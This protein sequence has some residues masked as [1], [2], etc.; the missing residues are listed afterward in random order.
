MHPIFLEFGPLTIRYY[1]LMAAVGF[2]L[3]YILLSINRKFA[4]LNADDSS[5]LI[6][7]TLITGILGSRIFYVIQFFD[8]FRGHLI[9]IVRI[10]KGG[11]VFYGGFFLALIATI[12]FCKIKKLDTIRIFDV[13]TPSLAIGHAAGRVGCF[14]N[15]CCFGSPTDSCLGVI[16]PKFSEAFYRYAGAPVHPVQLYEAFFN[17][18]IC[19][20]AMILLRK[21]KRGLTSG[22]YFVAYGIMRFLNEFSRGDHILNNSSFTIA[23]LIGFCILPA[24]IIYFTIFLLKKNKDITC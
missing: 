6:F 16:Y 1:G 2:L 5:N 7:V 23:Q 17:I 13:L 11:L 10:D 22:F 15:G 4:S 20:V 8:Q 18:I 12:I 14:L 21:T 9:D 3:A 24:G 19:I